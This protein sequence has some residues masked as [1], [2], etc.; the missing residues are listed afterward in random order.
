[1][2]VS[3]IPEAALPPVH[4]DLRYVDPPRTQAVETLLAWLRYMICAFAKRF[5]PWDWLKE[6][7]YLPTEDR[8]ARVLLRTWLEP[9]EQVLRDV[10]D[11]LARPLAKEMLKA[12]PAHVMLA[13]PAPLSRG[14]F[15]LAPYGARV[16]RRVQRIM[17]IA[18]D[19]T[20]AVRARA[21]ALLTRM[22]RTRTMQ[23]KHPPR[24]RFLDEKVPVLVIP[25][26]RPPDPLVLRK[27]SEAK[28]HKRE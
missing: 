12:I 10:V 1:M 26:V 8:F 2:F 18:Q 27:L 14:G 4:A 9:M 7:T 21:N 16:V 28:H 20:V 11:R 23:E 19:P 22:L 6:K 13:E 15:T 3:P 17:A 24:M 5:G 25:Q